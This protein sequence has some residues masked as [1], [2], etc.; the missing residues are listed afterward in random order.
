MD[1]DEERVNRYLEARGFTPEPFSKSERRA[2]KTPDFRVLLEGEFAFYCE[3]KSISKD[4]W[5]DKELEGV[6]PGE[7]AGGLRNTP[8]YNRLTTDIYQALKQF[9]AV[10]GG[11][12][13]PNALALVNHD[14]MCGFAD[15]ISVLTGN[16]YAKDGTVEPIYRQ[17]SHGRIKDEK[18]KIHLVIWLDDYKPDQLLFSQ[19]NE[20]HHMS[21]CTMLGVSQNEIKQIGS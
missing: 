11:Q 18:R 21:L 7:L 14:H 13:Y 15:L 1:V 10:N 4:Q 19:T 16:F 6:G 8:I 17:F 12:N 3:V 2:G 5:L 9:D 20:V